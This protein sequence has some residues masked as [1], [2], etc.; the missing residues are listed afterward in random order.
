MIIS[1]TIVV[2]SLREILFKPA[3][4]YEDSFPTGNPFSGLAHL[5]A[6]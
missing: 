5:Y 4:F 2:D 1:N 6:D 3:L